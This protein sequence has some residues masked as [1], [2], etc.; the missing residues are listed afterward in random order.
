MEDIETQDKNTQPQQYES[1][2]SKI[3]DGKKQKLNHKNKDVNKDE[4]SQKTPNKRRN[5]N[6]PNI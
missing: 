3:E 5:K 6:N 1:V 4:N 2:I